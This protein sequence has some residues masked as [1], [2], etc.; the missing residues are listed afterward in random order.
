MEIALGR[1]PPPPEWPAGIA[2]R[3]LEPGEEERAYAA[4][5]ESFEDHWEHVETPFD[6]WL[7]HMAG[8]GFDPAHW[9]L[10]LDGDEVAGVCLCRDWT[11]AG[12][13]I[14]WVASLGVR[15]PWRR[16][17]LGR[18]LLLHAF[19]AFR[20][21]G[22]AHAGLSVDGESL[23]GAVRLYERAGMHVESRFDTWELVLG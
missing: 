23:T 10:A 21:R 20:G 4:A 1:E 7:H 3:P 15:R 9:F 12:E 13:T 18:A 5:D 14:G 2:V 19:H 17:G 22:L 8:P 16:R 11:R 6:E